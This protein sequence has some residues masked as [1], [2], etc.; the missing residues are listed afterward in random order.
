MSGEEI[1][2]THGNIN[3]LAWLDDRFEV[4]FSKK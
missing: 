4:R 1:T 2:V 3:I